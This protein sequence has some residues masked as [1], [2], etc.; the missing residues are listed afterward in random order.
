M[1]KKITLAGEHLRF[2]QNNEGAAAV[3]GQTQIIE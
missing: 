1:I 3:P 2:E